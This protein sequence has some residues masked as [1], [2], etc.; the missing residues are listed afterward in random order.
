[1]WGTVWC[2]HRFNYEV[3]VFGKKVCM[4]GSVCTL[5]EA[6][7]CGDFWPGKW[8]ATWHECEKGLLCC[9]GKTQSTQLCLQPRARDCRHASEDPSAAPVSKN[10]QTKSD[11][12]KAAPSHFPHRGLCEAASQLATLPLPR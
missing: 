12:D 8:F 11:G 7:R 9:C 4:P 6:D 5:P 1:M 3:G 10:H 2:K